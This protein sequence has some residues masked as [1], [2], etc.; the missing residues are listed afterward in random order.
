MA[1]KVVNG[2]RN[3]GRELNVLRHL[4]Q[5]DVARQNESHPGRKA[6]IEC[7]DDFELGPKHHCLVLEVMGVDVQALID[8][9]RTGRLRRETAQKIAR[10]AVEGLDY[11][12]RCGVAHG[13]KFVAWFNQEI[14]TLLIR[15]CR[16]ILEKYTFHSIESGYLI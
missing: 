7:F 2:R 16:F 3:D 5:S 9:Q 4:R 11:I 12:W 1:L 10:R 14:K 13:G 8:S 15:F 6:V